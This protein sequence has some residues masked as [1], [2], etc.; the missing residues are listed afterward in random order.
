MEDQDAQFI[1][2]RA[3]KSDCVPPRD[4]RTN[5]YIAQIGRSRTISSH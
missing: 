4:R 1:V 5:R 3:A 2:E